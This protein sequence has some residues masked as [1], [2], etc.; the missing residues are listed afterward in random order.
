MDNKNI[1][2]MVASVINGDKEEFSSSFSSEM[3]DRIASKFTEKTTELSRDILSSPDAPVESDDVLQEEMYTFKSTSDAKK[4]VTS[5][6]NAGLTKRNFKVRGK[7][8]DVSG[9]KD[10]EMNQMVQMLAQE[11]KATK[12]G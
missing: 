7:T 8:V 12:K 5:A 3:Q 4:F 10:K 6:S 11:M 9:V 1:D 2:N